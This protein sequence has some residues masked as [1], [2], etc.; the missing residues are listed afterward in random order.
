MKYY[1]VNLD[2]K[3]KKCLLIGGGSVGS[4]KAETLLECGAELTVVSPEVTKEIQTFADDGSLRLKKRHY[5][6]SDIDEKIFLV[7]GATD[8]DELN[9]QIHKDAEQF[10]LLCNIADKP[11]VCNFILPAIVHRG[12]LIIAVSTSGKSP[13]FAKKLRQRLEK[14]YGDE[15]AIFLEL[16]GA[17]RKKLL[18]CEHEPEAHK[19]L[20][21]Q[22][23]SKG[24]IDMIKNGKEAEID[25][26][27]TNLFG[28]E[29]Q[30]HNLQKDF[31]LH[32]DSPKNNFTF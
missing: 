11:K 8:N 31:R 15:Y 4:R 26:L 32:K 27:L 10:N 1:P 18:N 7:I 17:I 30:L 22:L 20:F 16:M 2:I 5:K 12:D 3:N 21:E 19:H 25:A 9:E 23:I 28:M 24:L 29:Y 6:S 14:E 13:A